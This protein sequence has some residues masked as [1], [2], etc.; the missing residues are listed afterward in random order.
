MVSKNVTLQNSTIIPPCFIGEKVV[1][2]NTTLGPNV[3]VGDGCTIENSTISD[4]LI[5]TNAKIKN[6]N[7]QEAMI[8]NYAEFDGNFTKIS[9]GDYCQLI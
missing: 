3:S 4:S 8:G 9:I 2:I 1:L 5:Q 7:L 6:A